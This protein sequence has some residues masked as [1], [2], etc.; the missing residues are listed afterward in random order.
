M[1]RIVAIAT[2]CLFFSAPALG[3]D[4][5]EVCVTALQRSDL[6]EFTEAAEGLE[7]CL[8]SVELTPEQ[9]VMIYAE[10]GSV[11]MAMENYEGALQAFAFTFAIAETQG[12]EISHPMIYR[13]R[14]ISLGQTGEMERALGDLLRA[15]AMLGDDPLTLVNLGWVYGQLERH[16]DA[17]V[18][19]D[20]LVRT[21][22]DWSGAWLNRS[23]AFLDLGMFTEAVSDARRAVEI[24][25][26]DG[27]TLNM[28]CWTLIQ[29]GRAETALPLCRQAA[30]LE[31]E[32][33]HVIHSL[34]TALEATGS[35][36]RARRLFGE[37]FELEPE[38]PD[39]IADYERTHRP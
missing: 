30:E 22:P 36:R 39:I 21:E 10:L 19:Y 32:S 9:E 15:Y 25:P 12:A 35:A 29:D 28:L 38:D 13:N 37:A 20:M 5:D 3:Q 2:L 11:R 8:A 17:V 4:D 1:N 6:G 16:E 31:P 24:D 18:I 26:E 34:A 23:A 14:G 33:G 27:S 7:N